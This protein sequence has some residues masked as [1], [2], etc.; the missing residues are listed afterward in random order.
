MNE[1]D[2]V[3][4]IGKLAIAD[5]HKIAKPTKSNPKNQLIAKKQEVSW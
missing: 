2:A 4:Y 5:N 1:K 3:E